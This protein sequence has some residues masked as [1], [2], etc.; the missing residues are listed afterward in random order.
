MAHKS[1]RIT[2]MVDILY[3]LLLFGLMCTETLRSL[4]ASD[5]ADGVG[6]DDDDPP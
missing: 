1:D 3:L 4:Y 2:L 5:D 6:D